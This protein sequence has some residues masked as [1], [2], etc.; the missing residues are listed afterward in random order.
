[1]L[2]SENALRKQL[3]IE[4]R[5]VNRELAAQVICKN[6]KQEIKDGELI[7]TNWNG[8]QDEHISCAPLARAANT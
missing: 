7:K 6:C 2:T 8:E 3:D 4:Q 1:M 5:I